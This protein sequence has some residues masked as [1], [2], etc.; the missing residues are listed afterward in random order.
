MIV[1]LFVLFVMI[2]SSVLLLPRFA[3]TPFTIYTRGIFNVV[4]Y[5]SYQFWYEL[6]RGSF[7]NTNTPHECACCGLEL[8]PDDIIMNLN[9]VLFHADLY[10]TWPVYKNSRDNIYRDVP[11]MTYKK[12][13]KLRKQRK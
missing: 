1:E 11:T 6:F 4:V 3:M 13:L 10:C 12:W 2:F 7:S 9:G 8:K 5:L